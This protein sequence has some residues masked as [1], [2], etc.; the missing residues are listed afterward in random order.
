LIVNFKLYKKFELDCSIGIASIDY[1]APIDVQI[2]DYNYQN[3]VYILNTFYNDKDYYKSFDHRQ[4]AG[5]SKTVNLGLRINYLKFFNKNKL[6]KI[7]PFFKPELS[8]LNI[9]K[10]DKIP[11]RNNFSINYLLGLNIYNHINFSIGL[12]Q[13]K[14][15]GYQIVINYNQNS[16]TVTTEN[17]KFRY[18]NLIFKLNY[19]F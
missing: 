19:E 9:P 3:S 17:K 10:M 5:I 8:Y 7:N 16:Q 6:Y 14:F 1:L 2:S 13:L 18:N 11:F 12:K 15:P 4:I